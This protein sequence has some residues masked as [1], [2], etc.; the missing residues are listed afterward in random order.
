[1]WEWFW[2]YW[3]VLEK[4]EWDFPDSV[5]RLS[6]H[7]FLGIYSSTRLLIYD[8]HSA[9]KLHQMNPFLLCFLN[10]G[11][12]FEMEDEFI[13]NVATNLDTSMYEVLWKSHK[14]WLHTL[15]SPLN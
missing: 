14:L 3:C 11:L 4:P 8:A 2:K 5:T 7:Y 12:K 13:I 9:Y 1:M 10:F 15:P 6:P